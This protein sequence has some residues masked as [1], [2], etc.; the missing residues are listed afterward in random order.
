MDRENVLDQ[1]PRSLRRILE[2]VNQPM[3]LLF[4]AE[5]WVK[6]K[7]ECKHFIQHSQNKEAAANGNFIRL[8][9]MKLPVNHHA[10]FS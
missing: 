4:Q 8:R 6:K 1:Q 3:T 9:K 7:K 2:S 5:C 10:P